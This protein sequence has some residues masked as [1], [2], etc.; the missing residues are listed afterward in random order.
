[1]EKVICIFGASITWGAWDKELGGWANRLRIYFDNQPDPQVRVYNLGISGDKTQD[2]IKRFDAEAK[3]RKPDLIIFCIGTNDSKHNTNPNGTPP[4]EIETRYNNLISKAKKFT[5]KVLILGITNV[6][7]NNEK[8]YKNESV[9]VVNRIIEKLAKKQNLPF[10]DLFG[11]LSIDE[12]ED[13]LHPNAKGHQKIFEKV[14][15]AVEI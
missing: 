5:E 9:E 13:G 14:K 4:K 15:E 2:L 3:A 12:F 8:G 7:D 1:M 10:V 11:I 6:D